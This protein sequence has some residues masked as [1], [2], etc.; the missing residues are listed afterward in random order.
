M[1]IRF[2]L[3]SL[4]LLAACG[5]SGSDSTTITTLAIQ[6]ESLGQGNV[7]H[8]IFRQMQ[9]QGGNP[10]YEWSVSTAGD[11]LPEGISL[12]SAGVMI[13]IPTS[14]ASASLILV[15][16]DGFKNVD[17][18]STSLEV[19][20]IEIASSQPGTVD[21]GVSAQLQATGGAAGYVFDFSANQSGA[22]LDASGAYTAGSAHGVDVVRAT[23]QDG[24]FDEIAITVGDDPFAG[25]EARAGTDVWWLQWDVS[26]DPTPTYA[27]DIDEVLAALGLRHQ[28]STDADGTTEDRLAR[29]LLIRRTLGYVSQFY[30]NGASGQA[31]P[32]GFA[33]SFVK[34]GGPT[35]GSTP[36]PGSAEFGNPNLYNT[37]CVRHGPSSGI[38]G[39][40]LVDAGNNFIE[41][42]CGSSQGTA[43]GVFANRLL[44]NQVA[45]YGNALTRSP[46]QASDIPQLEAMLLG[47]EPAHARAQLIFDAADN[48]GRILAA[49]LAHEIGHS[50]GLNH[51]DPMMSNGDIMNSS[52]T[53]G[54][55]VTYFFNAGH[56][57]QLATSLPGVNR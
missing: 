54:G 1:Q 32:G 49:V 2:T 51:T 7:G 40:A 23:D 13:G 24:F 44:A 19:R 21:P 37:M 48:F 35:S 50:L 43:L 26:Y 20:D 47:E 4:I 27:S 33:I 36:A 9:A 30:G 25:F 42:D 22:A 31:Q 57:A 8:A 34:P 29:D 16:E 3:A 12:T 10:P 38:V 15:V 46:I 39:T 52:L 17:V 11:Q 53:I 5:G 56:A 18:L 45:A 28:S 6:T 55:G 14:S 41:H